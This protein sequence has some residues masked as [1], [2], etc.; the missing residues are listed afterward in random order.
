MPPSNEVGSPHRRPP[1][2]LRIG[3]GKVAETPGLGSGFSRD[4]LNAMLPSDLPT[5]DVSIPGEPRV[6]ASPR[7]DGPKSHHFRSLGLEPNRCRSQDSE[8]LPNRTSF[9]CSPV[10]PFIHSFIQL[11]KVSRVPGATLHRLPHRL[12]P[13]PHTACSPVGS[14]SNCTA[15]FLSSEARPPCSGRMGC[16]TQI[17]LRARE[18]PAGRP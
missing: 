13:C 8:K 2:A 16:G 5:Q 15:V 1:S 10:Q 18:I 4:F 6:Y 7:L 12:S 11:T 9:A 3:A 14:K 17:L